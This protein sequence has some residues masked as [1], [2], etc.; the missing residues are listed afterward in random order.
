VEAMLAESLRRHSRW[1]DF[2]GIVRVVAF[3]ALL[4]GAV[5]LLALGAAAL[6][7]WVF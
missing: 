2:F 3:E 5:A 1:R 7:L 6:M 4:V